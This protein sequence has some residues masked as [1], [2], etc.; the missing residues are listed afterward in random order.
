MKY[1]YNKFT[2]D[3]QVTTGIE[4]K[5]KEVPI[6]EKNTIQLQIWDTVSF[7][8]AR[9]AKRPSNQS[10]KAAIRVSQQSSFSTPYKKNR[11]SIVST[12]GFARSK[13]TFINKVFCSSVELNWIW[14]T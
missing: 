8:L 4:C 6:N 13:I 7:S 5:T 12:F 2:Y 9:W 3:Y 11:A 14:K 10:L 1:V